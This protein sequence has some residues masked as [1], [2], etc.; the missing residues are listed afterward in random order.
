MQ[1]EEGRSRYQSKQCQSFPLRFINTYDYVY[2]FP[3]LSPGEKS[4]M[5]TLSILT[6]VVVESYKLHSLINFPNVFWS[7]NTFNWFTFGFVLQT[8]SQRHNDLG[9]LM[10]RQ[11][12]LGFDVL[13]NQMTLTSPGLKHH[14][15][16]WMSNS[17]SHGGLVSDSVLHNSLHI[18]VLRSFIH[19]TFDICWPWSLL[20]TPLRNIT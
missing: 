12:R 17:N 16:K 18:E 11:T 1:Q 2:Y 14:G 20:L 6:Y 19:A 3:H 9:S 4:K 15:N 10:V 13:P 7:F 5:G 8:Q